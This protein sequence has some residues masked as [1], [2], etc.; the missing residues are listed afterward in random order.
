MCKKKR[1]EAAKNKIVMGKLCDEVFIFC[2]PSKKQKTK[3]SKRKQ[4]WNN[5]KKSP[6]ESKKII[7]I[8]IY[9]TNF[10][11]RPQCFK[12]VPLTSPNTKSHASRQECCVFPPPRMA[13]LQTPNEYLGSLIAHNSLHDLDP[14]LDA[15][16]A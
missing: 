14:D 7:S 4:C 6:K 9:K 10:R 2:D 11:F 16:L 15:D 8:C 3:N 1:A 12:L 5:N 13:N